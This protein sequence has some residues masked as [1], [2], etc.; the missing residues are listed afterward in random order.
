MRGEDIT[1]RMRQGKERKEMKMAVTRWMKRRER[2][3]EEA[4]YV[5]KERK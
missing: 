2:Q 5:N 3:G 4:G 1:E